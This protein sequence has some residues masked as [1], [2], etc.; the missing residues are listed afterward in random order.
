VKMVFRD[1]AAIA[2]GFVLHEVPGA[3]PKKPASGLIAFR[4]P[5]ASGLSQAIS[6]PTV[7]TFQPSK[8][9]GG[10][11]IA[12]FVFPHAE[13][14]AAVTYVFSPCGSSTPRMS[15]CSASQ[16]SSRAM[17]EAMRRA[18]HFLPSRALPP[19]PEPY[20]QI[21]RDSGKWT[22]YFSELHGQA[23]SLCPGARGA[24]T[25]CIQGTTRLSPLSISAMTA[26]PIRA[27]IRMLTTT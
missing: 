11:S 3:T 19:Y 13:G 4:R 18:K 2:F 1:S 6:S 9:A 7:H 27:M 15:M 20:D 14:N 23:T 22:M 26:R 10:M 24:P 17:F 16:P 25:V 5:W 21:S 8:P 12:K